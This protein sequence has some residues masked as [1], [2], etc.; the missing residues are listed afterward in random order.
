[1]SELP[2]ALPQNPA[3]GVCGKETVCYDVDDVQCEGC[4]LCFDPNDDFAASFLD[5]DAEPCG[6]ACDNSWHGDHMIT[7]GQ[8]YDCGTCRLPTGHTSPFHYTGCVP[9][10]L[11]VTA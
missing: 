11:T 7:R 10:R 3:C 6:A 9:K 2:S 1:M 4:E 8:G 5:P